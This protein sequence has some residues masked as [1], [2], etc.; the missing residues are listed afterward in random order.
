MQIHEGFIDLKNLNVS[1]PD[2]VFSNFIHMY[3]LKIHLFSTLITN[4]IT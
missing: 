4:V 3:L 1:F 2:I